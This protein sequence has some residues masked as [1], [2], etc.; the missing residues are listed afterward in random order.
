MAISQRLKAAIQLLLFALL[1]AAVILALFTSVGC[2]YSGERSYWTRQ[3]TTLSTKN[4]HMQAELST[5]RLAKSA[6]ASGAKAKPTPPT[7]AEITEKLD[8]ILDAMDAERNA[9][10]TIEPM[11]IIP[12]SDEAA[13]LK[14]LGLGGGGLGG[15]GAAAWFG[16]QY[17]RR[18]NGKVE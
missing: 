12:D 16:F 14:L 2:V 18:R 4:I 11:E 7:S 5:L 9:I 15:M 8:E 6:R 17:G 13:L 1:G 3:I 10:V